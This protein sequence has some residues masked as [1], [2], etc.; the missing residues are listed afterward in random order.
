VKP[1]P[2]PESVPATA[3]APQ[4]RLAKTGATANGLLLM[5]GAILGGA[6]AGLLIL[7]LLEGRKHQEETAR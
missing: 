3:P 5:I 6:G 1:T 2:T 4:A 7:H